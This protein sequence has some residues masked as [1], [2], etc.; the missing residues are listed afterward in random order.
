MK[1]ILTT[2]ALI[3]AASPAPVLAQQP[4]Q[5]IATLFN[6]AEDIKI[7]PGVLNSFDKFPYNSSLELAFRR[8]SLPTTLS[9][10]PKQSPSD[11]ADLATKLNNPIA[12]LISVPFQNNFDYKMGPDEG[13]F[14]YTLNLQP[15]IPVRL[16]NNWNLI[17]RTITPFIHQHD[18]IGTTSTTGLGD[19]TQSLFLSPAKTELFIWGA[20]PAFLIPTATD[21]Q[22]GTDKF[23]IGP[24]LVILK[25]T[26]GWTYGALLNH[27]WSVAGDD[28]AADVSSTFMQ[29]FLAYTTRTAWTFAL[30]TESSYDWNAEQWSIPIH[31][32]AS[33]LVTLGQQRVSIGGGLRCWTSTTPSGPEGC[34]FRFFVTPVFPKA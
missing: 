14:R 26:S 25:Q 7:R 24:T 31:A 8:T 15:V 19:I 13:G 2:I 1:G 6:T 28:D 23:G 12:S 30:N 32:V 4:E 33:K 20:G 3:C 18:A 10:L 9:A 21:E 11:A 17:S 27:I 22:L 29:P 5:Q 16:T 34:G